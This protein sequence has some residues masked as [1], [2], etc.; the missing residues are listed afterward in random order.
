ME[1]GR[2]LLYEMGDILKG[3]LQQ[4]RLP[5]KS[6]IFYM[7]KVHTPNTLDEICNKMA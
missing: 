7:P 4:G 6:R 1:E 5:L 3:A 2:T